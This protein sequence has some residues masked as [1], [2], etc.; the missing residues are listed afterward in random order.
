MSKVSLGALSFQSFTVVL[1]FSLSF[2][3][4]RGLQKLGEVMKMDRIS[5]DLG[6]DMTLDALIS[7]AEQ[8]TRLEADALADRSTHVYNLQRKVRTEWAGG[9]TD[10]VGLYR[11]LTLVNNKMYTRALLTETF[12]IP[13]VVQPCLLLYTE[14][15]RPSVISLSFLVSPFSS[16]CSLALVGV[17]LDQSLHTDLHMNIFTLIQP[18]WLTW[19]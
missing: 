3:Y 1:L 16:S 9:T 5:L 12:S 15:V 17:F 14:G 18:V 4:L 7:R 2:Q 6:L 8:L 11:I 13:E 19:R 10:L